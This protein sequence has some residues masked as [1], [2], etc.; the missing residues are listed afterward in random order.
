MNLPGVGRSESISKLQRLPSA[1]RQASADPA[2][3]DVRYP[4][5]DL[6]RFLERPLRAWTV[7]CVERSE[8]THLEHLEQ[9]LTLGVAG[10]ALEQGRP[11]HPGRPRQREPQCL[12]QDLV[13]REEQRLLR[14]GALN[15]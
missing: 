9:L 14:S 1:P 12:E 8:P 6:G 15:R 3:H 4:L 11:L 5:A 2:G 13:V 7:T 10:S